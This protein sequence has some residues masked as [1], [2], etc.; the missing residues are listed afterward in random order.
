ME[1]KFKQLS[2]SI[3]TM[4]L[5]TWKELLR[6][7]YYPS[8][9]TACMKIPIPSLPAPQLRREVHQTPT[10]P[11]YGKDVFSLWNFCDLFIP[12]SR[13]TTFVG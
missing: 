7:N 2:I 13:L 3:T 8:P 10:L 6:I 9:E 5:C 12:V 4:A 1:S 11:V